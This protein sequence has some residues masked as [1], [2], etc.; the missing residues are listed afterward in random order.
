VTASRR[1]LG[2]YREQTAKIGV[3]TSLTVDALPVTVRQFVEGH[4]DTATGVEVLLLLHRE[5]QRAW[6]SGA[7]A[8]RMRLDGEQAE[9][10]L[11]GLEQMGLARRQDHTFEY[12]P[13]TRELASAV[14]MLAAAYSRYRFRIIWLIFSKRPP[15]TDGR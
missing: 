7:V 13:R 15:S 6:S 12:A 2:I 10:I 4:F 3:V 5:P 14:E 1:G 11:D 8:G 9:A